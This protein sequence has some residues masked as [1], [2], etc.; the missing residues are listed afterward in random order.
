MTGTDTPTAEGV[1][2]PGQESS[3][4]F[5]VVVDQSEELPVAINYACE[6]ARRTGGRVALLYVY[7]VEKDF[8]HWK[9]VSRMAD[10]EARAE[11]ENIL[12]LHALR[13]VQETGRTPDTYVREGDRRA[14]LFALIKEHPEISMLVLSSAP[15]NKPGPLVAAVT[16]KFAGK[17]GI[18]VTVIPATSR[19]TQANAAA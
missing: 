5:L 11:A 18:P 1:K 12:K 4:L 14:E 19:T 3:R 6:R 17:I 10:A 2:E 7:N 16:G 8:H 9:F 15:G 13:V